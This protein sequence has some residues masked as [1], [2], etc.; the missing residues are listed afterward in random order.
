MTKKGAF[1]IFRQRKNNFVRLGYQLV[2]NLIRVYLHSLLSPGFPM[3]GNQDDSLPPGAA[4][5]PFTRE[6]YVPLSG[7]QRGRSECPSCIARFSSI[8][9][10]N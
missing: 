1:I 10:S 2:N 9:N 6:I 8:F 3:S 7:R 4:R 5:I